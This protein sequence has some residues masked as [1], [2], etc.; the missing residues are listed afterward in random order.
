MA[1]KFI[2]EVGLRRRRYRIVYVS[3]ATLLSLAVVIVVGL[4]LLL[5]NPLL[6]VRE[7]NITGNG[8]IPTA[9]VE[10]LLRARVTGD[11]WFKNFLGMRN[12]LVWPG[13]LSKDDLKLLPS[14]ASVAIEKDILHG[15]VTVTVKERGH[16]GVWCFE[17][18]NPSACY[19]FDDEGL[20]TRTPRTEGS[21]ILVVDD[22][23]RTKPEVG[24]PLIDPEFLP[25]LFSIFDALG[26]INMTIKEI[27]LEDLSLEEIKVP[28]FEGPTLYFSLRFP[29]SATPAAFQALKEKTSIKNLEYIDFRA[30]NKVYYK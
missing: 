27:R 6:L 10:T 5:R 25:N 2:S 16:E 26:N 28:T 23:A 11:S 15:I 7:V 21:L 14:A 12:M 9:D 24:K 13:S 20:V 19:W 17:N 3:T 8:Y 4:L 30:E 1:R 22:Y 29:A 18:T